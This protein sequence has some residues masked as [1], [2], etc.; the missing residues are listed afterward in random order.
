MGRTNNK[1]SKSGE[2]GLFWLDVCA[3][4][5]PSWVRGFEQCLKVKMDHP[6][7]AVTLRRVLTVKRN[8]TESGRRNRVRVQGECWHTSHLSLLLTSETAK[9]KRNHPHKTSGSVG[10]G[11][12]CIFMGF[13]TFWCWS[14]EQ[15]IVGSSMKIKMSSKTYHKATIMLPFI[16]F[17][18]STRL[19]CWYI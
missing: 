1:E 6:P 15:D 9:Q 17:R 5:M 13:I 19:G 14:N 10:P 8:F 2:E 18:N 4:N 12:Q 11:F 16:W 7:Q 3:E